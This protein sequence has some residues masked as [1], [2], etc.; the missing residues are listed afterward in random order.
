VVSATA[1]NAITLPRA[2]SSS[3]SPDGTTSLML[4]ILPT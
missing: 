1:L 3:P 4:L 2:V